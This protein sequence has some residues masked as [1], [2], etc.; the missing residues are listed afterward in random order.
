MHQNEA[1]PGRKFQ[2]FPERGHNPLFGLK[3]PFVGGDTPHALMPSASR[4][5][6]LDLPFFPYEILDTP[7]GQN[8]LM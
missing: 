3:A 1:F 8:D 4:R 5:R 7:L 6:C 2:N